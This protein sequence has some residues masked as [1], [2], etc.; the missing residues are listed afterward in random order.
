MRSMNYKRLACLLAALAVCGTGVHFLHGF[1]VKHNAH[2]VRDRAYREEEQNHPAQ[3]IKYLQRYLAYVPNDQEARA[4]LGLLLS[5]GAKVTQQGEKAYLILTSVLRYLP[6]RNDLRR[7]AVVLALR[8]Q[9]FP[10]AERLLDELPESF[11]K[12]GKVNR[13]RGECYAAQKKFAKA[14]EAY[15]EAVKDNPDDVDSYVFRANVLRYELGNRRS[16]VKPNKNADE[17][18]NALVRINPKSFRAHLAWGQYWRKVGDPKKATEGVTTAYKLAP[19]ESDVLIALADLARDQKPKADYDKARGYLAHNLELHPQDPRSYQ[20]LAALEL[21]AGRRPKAIACLRK[22]A[23]ADLPSEGRAE[24]VWALANLLIETKDGSQEAVQVLKKASFPAPRVAFIKAAALAQEGQWLKATRALERVRSDALR[25]PDLTRQVDLALGRC[26]GQLGDPARQ[27]DAYQRAVGT[28]L[29]DA[30]TVLAM[31][32]ALVA[33]GKTAAAIELYRVLLPRA[34][35]DAF[36]QDIQLEIAR[37]LI[38]QNLRRPARQRN[39]SE[40]ER[41][42]PVRPKD[43]T[44]SAQV[45]ILRAEV[46]ADRRGSGWLVRA[47]DELLWAQ[48]KQSDDATLWVARAGLSERAGKPDEAL[49][50]LDEAEAKLGDRVE[51]RLARA[52]CWARR[53]G[54]AART[55]LAELAGKKD[56]FSPDDHARLTRSLAAA[57]A[58]IGDLAEAQQLW[59]ELAAERPNDLGVRLALFNLALQAGQTPEILAALKKDPEHVPDAVRQQLAA[60]R[61]A[62]DKA[63]EAIRNIEGESGDLGNFQQALLLTWEARTAGRKDDLAKAHELLRGVGIRRP[64]WSRVPAAAADIDQLQDNIP[65]AIEDLKKAVN[66]LDDNSPATIRQLVRLLYDQKRFAEA[67]KALEKLPDEVAAA[68]DMMRITATVSFENQQYGRAVDLAEKAVSDQSKDYHDL[69]WL[70]MMRSRTPGQEAKAEQALRKA[71][72]LA[73]TVPDTWVALIQYL[74]ARGELKKAE[75]AYGEAES[76]LPPQEHALALASCCET[77]AAAY[78]AAVQKERAKAQAAA[79]QQEKAKPAEA[80]KPLNPWAE[81]ARGLYESVLAD[82]PDDARALAGLARY[83]LRQGE[84]EDAKQQLTKLLAARNQSREEIAW[85]TRLMALLDISTDDYQKSNEALKLLGIADGDDPFAGLK[86]MQPEDL[87]ARA[88]VLS[89]RKSRGQRLEAIALLEKLM[90]RDRLTPGDRMLLAQLYD[91]V[92]EWQKARQQLDLLVSANGDNPLLLG[93]LVEALVR[94]RELADASKWLDQLVTIPGAKGTFV[95]AEA[96]ARLLAAQGRGAAAV[97]VLDQYVADEA[98]PANATDRR[99]LAAGLLDDLS[100]TAPGEKRYAARAEELYRAYTDERPDKL[101]ALA[102]FLSRHGRLE[103]A[104]RTC[105]RAWQTKCPAVPLAQVSVRA[106]QAGRPDARQ[107]QLVDGWLEAALARQPGALKLLVCQ[108]YLRDLQGRHDEAIRLYRQILER[109]PDNAVVLNNLATLLI[110][111]E[112]NGPEA[113]VA[114]D[115]AIEAAGPLAE[116]RDTRALVNLSA[117]RAGPAIKELEEVV[118]EK[119]LAPGYYHLA[120]AYLQDGKE[121]EARRCWQKAVAAGLSPNQLHPLE[122]PGYER[123]LGQLGQN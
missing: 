57:F 97:A 35:T 51:L 43:G 28:E 5:R 13:L 18:M 50:I 87:R 112:G 96:R 62:M 9:R 93:Y 119:P 65:A 120:E 75:E 29:N 21:A 108:A 68:P 70:G 86:Q 6:E 110:L 12:E 1:Q 71:V 17:V 44:E 10:D 33:Q 32:S 122:R 34:A 113:L 74:A 54:K 118:A 47:R 42:L 94:H 27:Y 20:A 102:A 26:Y 104:L 84:K 53:G 2:A 77:L 115:H 111:R 56:H 60:A 79:S 23:E 41:Y 81:K 55:A 89:T 4:R 45:T 88:L 40:V 105:E 103:E 91:S 106:L 101:T 31:A 25:W 92:G 19:D 36:R 30:P 8:L 72:E 39:W 85:A 95:V 82:R 98:Q 121:V 69:L 109:D 14:D 3:A 99:G 22:G 15:A 100:R 61:D 117:G 73:D 123:L 7:E 16:E 116:L 37:L 67:E 78:A 76:K 24:V 107:Y 114:I 83:Y 64:T 80:K 38:V 58:Q 52:G 46:L 49:A 59:Q 90:G 48:G 63:L 11:W 66:E